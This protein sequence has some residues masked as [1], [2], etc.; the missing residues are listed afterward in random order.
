MTPAQ[1]AGLTITPPAHSDSEFQLTVTAT[2]TETSPTSGNTT[3]TT[4]AA[5][6]SATIDVQVD[7][8]AD[9]PT[10]SVT[11][12]VVGDE[13]NA[14]ALT[15]TSSLLD[16]DSSET[17]SITIDGV[18]TGA[19]FE[20]GHGQSGWL[21][22]PDDH[23]QPA[24]YRQLGNPFH[25][26]R[27]CAN[28]SRIDRAGTDN[29]DGSWTLTP[30]QLAGLTIT[31]PDDNDG[32]FQLT[33]TAIAT[34]T[35]PT[36]G[37][38]TVTTLA[39]QTSATIDVQVD[40]VADAPTLSVTSS[41]VGD[42]DHAIALTI[43]SSLLD[44]DSS[45]T[46]SITIDGVPTGAVF[47]A[48]TDNL[49]GSWTLTPAQLA[50]LTI[51]PPAHSDSEF[52]L[53]VTATA[54]ETSPTSG[55]TTVTTL[56]AQTSATIDV[57]VDAVADAPTLSVTSS[58]T[59]DED[60]AIA[61]TI[62]SSLLDTDSSETL[63]I[64]I[65]GVP[66]GAVLSAGTDNLDGSW[67]LTP[68]Q[69]AGL[70]ITPPADNDSEFQLTVTAT[71][72]E[73]SPTSGNTTVTTLAAQ[74]S[75]TIDVQ[76]DAVADA[77][78][79]SVTSSVVGD[80]D[81]AIALTIT[82]SLLD[83]DSSETLSITIDG[84]PTGAVLSAGTDNLDGSW[85]LTPAQLAGLTITPP[86]HSDSEFQL[87]VTATAT[88]TSPTSGDT[89]VTTLAAQTSATIDVRVDAV[90]DAPTLNVSLRPLPA[91]KTMPSP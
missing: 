79:L 17:L 69:L 3:V 9:A 40:A 81:N 23:Q 21:V 60:N 45:E 74:T 90:A 20:R 73:T 86:A 29:L 26:D 70:T 55:D 87:T 6:T 88:E 64:T 52:Q 39:A 2:A 25:H 47:S 30:A 36:S 38:T 67:T 56:A 50:G 15:I 13:D 58:V 54:T 61:L 85:T 75:A 27:R 37:N 59:G 35:S 53:T 34:E 28:R 49:D 12:S 63:S 89:T 44:T 10:L 1:L 51:T 32:E 33:V 11:S 41:V 18:P 83:T 14:I 8:V 84:V 31:P 48:G 77:P 43:T 5:Q 71:A 65:D 4:L 78:T 62:T 22:D 19:V 68:A 76:V 66:T 91:T 16:T 57:Q 42:E 82:S 80:E 7:A 24:G 72:T 46:L